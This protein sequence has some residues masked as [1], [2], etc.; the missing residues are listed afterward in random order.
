MGVLGT[1][2]SAGASTL[3]D[4]VATSQK[5]EST[6]IAQAISA[7]GAHTCAVMKDMRVMCWGLNHDGSLGIGSTAEWSWTAL[8][9][10]SSPQGT[11]LDGVAGISAGDHSCALLLDTTLRCWGPNRD[12]ELGDGTLQVEQREAV[13]VRATRGGPV[14]TNVAA[15]S[16]DVKISCAVMRNTTARCWGL[17]SQAGLGDGTTTNRYS[18]VVVRTRAGGPP[19]VGIV[20]VSAAGRCA[21]LRD[22]TV[23]C[24]GWNGHGNLGDGTRKDRLVPV[25]VRTRPR[26]PA[27]QRVTAIT[28]RS[29]HVCALMANTTVKCWGANSAGGLGDGTVKSRLSPVSVRDRPGGASLSG[30]VAISAGYY[31]TCA[32]LKD[33]TVRC[34]GFNRGGELGDG[35]G[36]DR[37]TPVAVVGEGGSRL[38]G[39]IAISAGGHHTCALLQ[40]STVVCWGVSQGTGAADS[41][42]HAIAFP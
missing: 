20:A 31:H 41:G 25:V 2:C 8:A 27:L 21:L 1:V 16:V 35:T 28:A 29:G 26:G 42:P 34:W 40:N 3:G 23:R 6:G 12:R 32:L 9:V 13:T 33:T 17:N 4:Q 39:A 36:K 18:P 24:W 10:R 14:L 7:G 15:V 22:T 37:S 19:L 11:E 5:L 38:E 30:V